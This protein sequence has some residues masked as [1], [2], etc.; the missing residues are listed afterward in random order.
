MK[1]PPI[2]L[3]V[4]ADTTI[5]PKATMFGEI[6]MGTSYESYCWEAYTPLPANASFY[7]SCCADLVFYN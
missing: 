5:V 3:F 2:T 4:F 6:E 1:F 7:L